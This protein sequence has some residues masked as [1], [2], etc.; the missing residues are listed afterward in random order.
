MTSD[1]WISKNSA[2]GVAF[3]PNDQLATADSDGNATVWER[4]HVSW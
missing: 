2:N 3:S 1:G 4:K